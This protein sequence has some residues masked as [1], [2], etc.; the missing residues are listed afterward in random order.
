MPRLFP[1]YR[2]NLQPIF[3]FFSTDRSNR[4]SPFFAFYNP[5]AYFSSIAFGKEL[6]T[7]NSNRFNELSDSVQRYR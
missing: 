6:Y 4:I 1:A 2:F 3:G 5:P 7:Q